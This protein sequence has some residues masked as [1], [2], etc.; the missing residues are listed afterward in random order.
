MQLAK[1]AYSKFNIFKTA[2]F[3]Y[4]QNPAQAVITKFVY[5]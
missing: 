2:T 3:V 5:F 4:L 1:Q